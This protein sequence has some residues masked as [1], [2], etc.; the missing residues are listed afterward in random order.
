MQ[1]FHGGVTVRFCSLQFSFGTSYFFLK[2]IDFIYIFQL[3]LCC[4]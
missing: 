1:L 4:S 2:M 3:R